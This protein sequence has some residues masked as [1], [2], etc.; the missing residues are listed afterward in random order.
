MSVLERAF[1]QEEIHLD[2][3]GEADFKV[4]RHPIIYYSKGLL[5]SLLLTVIIQLV[6][7]GI[8]VA[9][10]PVITVALSFPATYLLLRTRASTFRSLVL[11]TFLQSFCPLALLW[12]SYGNTLAFVVLM[13][14]GEAIWS[15]RLY[16]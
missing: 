7:S 6:F 15:P 16:E 5:P 3:D 1:P 8:F 4:P 2:N 12:S 13:A 14:C 11:G 10:E 9:I